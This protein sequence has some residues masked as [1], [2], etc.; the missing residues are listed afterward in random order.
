MIWNNIRIRRIHYSCEICYREPRL[1]LHALRPSLNY[2]RV[3]DNLQMLH[4]KESR[5]NL[6]TSTSHSALSF[7]RTPSIQR[8]QSLEQ[9]QGLPGISKLGL[10]QFA[11]IRAA[12]VDSCRLSSLSSLSPL[13]INLKTGFDTSHKTSFIP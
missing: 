4:Q 1:K 9:C 8:N 11:W 12:V 2:I 13:E 6:R 7:L 5:T 10:S 3:N